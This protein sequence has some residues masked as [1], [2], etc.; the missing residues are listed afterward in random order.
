MDQNFSLTTFSKSGKL[1][2]IENALSAVGN[3]ETALGIKAKDGVVIAVEKKPSSSLVDQSS[4]EKVQLVSDHCGATYAGLTADFRVLM[5][6][7]RKLAQKYVYAYHQESL[8]MQICK[9]AASAMQESTQ[10]GGVR[11]YGIS[12]L[13]GG[14]DEEGPH[15]YQI[16]PSGAYIAWKAT[17]LGKNMM[18]AKTFLEKRYNEDI[19][20]EDAIHMAILTL[21]EG[22]EGK[23]TE[24]N[25]EIGVVGSDKKFRVL[26][27]SQIK[28]YIDEVD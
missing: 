13:V 9:K 2:Q 27:P 12:L 5:D 23:M 3:G 19:E 21:K 28:D 7:T 25:I 24:N 4:I 11:P 22:F 18:N 6:H 1:Q 14:H 8:V 26:T 15:L 10:S 16:D 17:A 20:L